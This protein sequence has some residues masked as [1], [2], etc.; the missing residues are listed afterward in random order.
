MIAKEYL[1]DRRL[2]RLRG[3]NLSYGV[4]S[5][6]SQA[7]FGLR[8]KFG[9][10]FIDNEY[11][12]SEQSGSARPL[13]ELVDEVP[14]SIELRNHLTREVWIDGGESFAIDKNVELHDWLVAAEERHATYATRRDELAS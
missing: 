12:Y 6:Q 3:R 13:Q 1:T 11:C 2:Y 4:W 5:A 7:F 10:I 8:E 14:P 9:H